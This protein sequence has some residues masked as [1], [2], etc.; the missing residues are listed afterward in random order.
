M[1]S[2]YIYDYV[3][4]EL[5]VYVFLIFVGSYC[6]VFD[7]VVE[8]LFDEMFG[9]RFWGVG[10]NFKIVVWEYFKIYFE[11]EIDKSI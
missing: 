1:D 4:V 7:I 2:N 10:N 6:V 9:D 11:F 3:L 8:D 5:E